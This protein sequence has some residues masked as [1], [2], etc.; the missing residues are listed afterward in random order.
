MRKVLAP[1]LAG[2]RVPFV[3][4]VAALQLAAWAVGYNR[5]AIAFATP[6][7]GLGEVTLSLLLTIVGLHLLGQLTLEGIARLGQASGLPA[8][9]AFDLDAFDEPVA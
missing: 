5:L 3:L 7:Q 4:T 8:V 1:A 6:L 2:V 9:G